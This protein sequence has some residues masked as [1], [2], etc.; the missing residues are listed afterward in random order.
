MSDA[1]AQNVPEA[2]A[3]IGMAGRFPGAKNVSEFWLN[4]KNG[5]ESITHFTD[6]ELDYAGSEDAS[7]R[8][9]ADYVKARPILEDVEMF[10]AAFFG[11]H[12]KEAKMMDPQQR[13]FLECAWESLENA[14]YDPE[15]YVDSIGVYA[16]LSMNTYLLS[17][18]CADRNFIEEFVGAYQ[19]GGYHTMMGNEKD[20][21][22]TRVSYKLNLKGPSI[23]VQ[24]A[25]STS[26]VAICQACLSLLN[27]QCDMA[28]AG[29]V[30]ITFPQKRGYLYQEGGMVSPDGHCRAFDANAQGTIFGSGV[31]VVTLKRLSD[32]IADGDHIYAI[33]KG[34]ALNND[35]SMKVGYTAPSVDRQAEVIAMAQAVAGVDAET[36]SYIEAHGTGTPLGDPIEIAALTQAFRA[37]TD[38]KGFCAVGSAKTNVGH[39]E[40]AAGVTGLIKAALSLK[41]G[42]LPPTLHFERPNPKIDFAN[43]PFYVNTKLTE[44]KTGATPRRAGVSA[45]GVGGTNA[46]V[47][48]EE[49]PPDET[50]APSRPWQLLLL[51]AKTSTALESATADLVEHFKQRPE[52]NLS[53]AAHTLQVGRRRFDHRRM[54]VCRDQHDASSTLETPNAKRVFTKSQESKSLSVVFMFPGQGAQHTRMGIELYQVEPEFREQVDLCCELLKPLLGLDLRD[55]LY[56]IDEKIEE[57]SELLNQT[58][59]TQPALF[60]IEYALAKLWQKWGVNPQAMIGHSLGEYVAA[61]L[62]GVISLEDV[63]GLLAARG[64]LIQQLPTGSM[65]A[66]RLPEREVSSLLGENLSIA[67]INAPSLCVVSG[68]TD[69]VKS[70]QDRIAAKGIA[71]RPLNASH[72]YHSAMMDPILSEFTALIGKVSFKP[73]QIPFISGVTGNWITA[74]QAIDPSYW[75]AQLR[76]TVRFTDGINE[77]LKEPGRVLLEV[78]PGQTLSGLAKQCAS[79]GTAESVFSSLSHAQGKEQDVASMLNALG[80]LW[81]SG[82]QVDWAGFYAD[83][84]RRRIDLPTYPF[85]RQRFWVEPVKSVGEGM[86]CTADELKK[87]VKAESSPPLLIVPTSEITTKERSLMSQPENTIINTDLKHKIISTLKTLLKNL[88]GIDLDEMDASETFLEMGFDSLFLTQASLTIQNE[89]GM[90]ISFRQLLDEFSTLESLAVHIEENLPTDHSFAKTTAVEQTTIP[91]S[92]IAPQLSTPA[93]GDNNEQLVYDGTVINTT[94][95]IIGMS[96]VPASADILERVVAQQLQV[97]SQQLAMLQNGRQVQELMPHAAHVVRHGMPTGNGSG[98]GGAHQKEL[99]AIPSNGSNDSAVKD[100]AAKLEFKSFGTYKPIGKKSDKELTPRQQAYLDNFIEG[101]VERT[102]ES[103]QLTQAHRA[104]LADPRVVAG[105][106]P[107]WKEMVYQIIVERSRGSRLWDVDGNEYVDLLNGFGL[108]LFGHSPAFITEAVRGQLAEGVE[109]GPQTPLAGQVAELISELTGM[110]RVTF[111]NT[112]SEAVMAA[113]RLARTVTGRHKVALFAGAYHGNTD[114]VLVRAGSG[115]GKLH[116]NPGAPGIP[117]Q[118]VG[119]VLVLDYGTD[120]SLEILKAQMHE[121]AA[122]LVEP[123]QTRHPDLQ[124]VA[125]LKELRRL[126]EQAG[127]AL[128]FDEV[129][130]GFRTHLGGAQALFGIRADMATYGK[131]VGGGMPIGIVAGSPAFMDALDGGA[132]N[133]GDQ[134][135][136]EAGVTFF[137]GTFTRHP[138][139]LAAALAVLKHLKASGPELQRRLNEKTTELVKALNELFEQHHVPTRIQHFASIFYFSFPVEEK[140]ASLLYYHLRRKGVHVLDGFP[141]FL[142]TAHTDEDFEFIIR[143]FTESVQEMQD[144][145]FFPESPRPSRNRL[146]TLD[147]NGNGSLGHPPAPSTTPAGNV[148]VGAHSGDANG[149]G[150]EHRVS[151]VPLTAAQKEIWFATQMSDASSCAF[152]DAVHVKIHGA[153]N[154]EAM[155]RAIQAIVNRHD[156]LR[157]TFKSSGEYQQ[158]SP[159]QLIEVQLVDMS[160]LRDDERAAELAKI[161]EREAHQPFDLMDGPLVRANLVKLEKDEY[162]LILMAHHIVCDGWSFAILLQELGELY[163]SECKGL[164]HQLSKPMQFSEYATW[165]AEQQQTLEVTAAESYWLGQFADS[166]PFLELPT[167]R[168]RPTTKTYNGATVNVVIDAALYHDLKRVGAK[169]GC[170]SFT[171]MLAGFEVLLHRLTGQEDFAVGIFAAGQSSVGRDDLVGH[172]ANMLPLRNAVPADATFAEHLLSL[173]KKVLSA[174]EH[175]NYT[176]GSLLEKL[177]LRNDASRTPPI[178]VTFNIDRA[179]FKG[180]DFFGLKVEVDAPQKSFVNFDL[181]FNI[182]ETDSGLVLDCHYSTDLFDA[183]TIR[184]LLNQYENLLRGIVANPEARISDL[185]LLASAER[186]KMLVVWNDTLSNYPRNKCLHQL[187]EEQAARTPD[188]VAVT[189][190]GEHMTYGELNRRANQLARHLRAWGVGHGALVGIL[191]ERSAVMLV[192]LLGIL[193]AGGAYVPMDPAYPQERLAFMLEDAGV[194]VLIT[195]SSLRERIPTHGIKMLCLDS[196]WASVAG[197]SAESINTDVA[198]VNTAYVIYTSGSTGKPKG[199]QIAHR[200]VVNFLISMLERPGLSNRDVLL[201]VTT[202]SFDIAGL[203]LYLPLTTGARVVIASREAAADGHQLLELMNESGATVLQATPVTWRLLLEAGWQGDARLKMLCGGEAL[204]TELAEELLPRGAELWNLYGPTETTIWSTVEQVEAAGP[205]LVGRPI[206]NTQVYIVDRQLNPVPLG[207]P[208]E[209]LI[210][211]DGLARGYLNRPELTAEK[212]ICSAWSE[213]RG[214]RLYRTG[215]LARY[216][217]DGKVE[218]LGRI[219]QQ[220][221]LRGHRIEL[222][223]IEAQLNRQPSVRQSVVVVREDVPGDKRLVAYVV[224]NGDAQGAAAQRAEDGVGVTR[225]QAQWEM[226]YNTAIDETADAK[227]SSPDLDAT[228]AGWTGLD[229]AEEHTREWIEQ[230]VERILAMRPKRVLEIGC[231]TGQ[232]LLRIAPQ[233][234]QYCGTDFSAAALRNLEELVRRPGNELPQVSLFERTADNFEGVGAEAFDTVIINSVVQYFPHIEYLVRVLEGAVRAVKPGG[235]IFLGDVQSFALLETYHA[236]AQLERAASALSTTQLMQNVRHRVAEENELVIDP[237]F[238]HALRERLP[239]INHVDIQLRR[240]RLQNETTKFHYDVI[241]STGVEHKDTAVRVWLD[242][243]EEELSLGALRHILG[244]NRFES[245]GITR[246]PNARLQKEV[247]TLELLTRSDRPQTVGELR[248]ELTTLPEGFDPENLWALGKELSYAIKIKW[249]GSGTSGHFDVLLK[250][251]TEGESDEDLDSGPFFTEELVE[252]K[253]LSHYA[254]NPAQAT[255]APGLVTELCSSLREKLPEYMVPSAFVVLDALPLTPNGKLDRRALPPP[256]Y[257]SASSDKAFVAPRNLQ[258]QMLAD[259]WAK[260][261]RLGRVSIHDSIFDLGGDSLLIFQITTRANQAGLQVTPKQFFQHRTIAGL[262]QA[263]AVD[264]TEYSEPKLQPSIIA[265][266]SR[267]ARRMKRSSLQSHGGLA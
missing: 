6:Q 139:A 216:T 130:T 36:I 241:L 28:L 2:V 33:I 237:A 231:G 66:V 148:M 223:E 118:N 230:T 190:D 152:N 41:H 83:E 147:V 32:A 121:L 23:T 217:A 201:A 248:E 218:I 183:E 40:V 115:G 74:A 84:R 72:A 31:G 187:I 105:F 257:I 239:Q 26:L 215:D 91:T 99:A 203:E 160:T 53:D 10:D 114:E 264:S 266:M 255:T 162:F 140:W 34:S 227:L 29:G 136:P 39:L 193:K 178:S 104:H 161:H 249:S 124:P 184:R 3:V 213:N 54:L 59:I 94:S 199:V 109:I 49:A 110:E 153:L 170:T 128:I 11:I 198:S 143:A 85:E 195:Q 64:R 234:E 120:E 112:G 4:L 43:S 141:C 18:L 92:H 101:Y 76:Q 205:V 52:L 169:K 79:K 117:Q 69:H 238:F 174:Y 87:S 158:S 164:P 122:V 159:H 146:T 157:T 48:L 19:V 253:P 173:K 233:C 132:W 125:F 108:N 78:G 225:W 176:Y 191:V 177:A 258:E 113:L 229:D 24:S 220:V 133:Y 12:P 70:L 103:K 206:A 196:D 131:V 175:Q 25:C 137:A 181:D 5:V 261:L 42:Q 207:V 55:V 212:F 51:S 7:L 58:W 73:P 8:S 123:V 22:S 221:K 35:G 67:A 47:V 260:V 251:R 210:G 20:F 265:A 209:L 14:G 156:A 37:S 245:F 61:C 208:G 93:L 151:E 56:P 243:K 155:R 185:P 168:P 57:A 242:W 192:G 254:N 82:A 219:D 182:V 90:K 236:S 232:L 214:A 17:N 186:H 13:F 202:L 226:L 166:L 81:L 126:T 194:K 102:R 38:A 180:L 88:S 60:V 246:V 116:T 267:D 179:G 96:V 144:A 240:G 50:P 119:N 1:E 189:C 21:L 16:G 100:D 204:P 252:L 63:L 111:C 68:P 45:F 80:R 167:D 244:E 135:V 107:Q 134:S 97:M 75:V 86:P 163:S 15:R 129:V 247:K 172:C 165:H 98:H 262:A 250:R 95:A 71:C 171:T 62:A 222:G 89:F 188:A 44:W 77:L 145:G 30:S 154:V 235:R 224:P 27:Y 142:T 197:E 259:I 149:N 127:T 65:L 106:R 211:G 150:N 200:A 256:D 263:F 9:D 228:I 138:V 46:H